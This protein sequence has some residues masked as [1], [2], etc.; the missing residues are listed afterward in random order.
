D[1]AGEDRSADYVLIR[2]AQQ[3]AESGE[4]D[5]IDWERVAQ[6]ALYHRKRAGTLADLY[7]ALGALNDL[8][9]TDRGGDLSRALDDPNGRRKIARTESSGRVRVAPD[10]VDSLSE[11]GRLSDANRREVNNLFGEGTSPKLRLI[12]T[13]LEAL[14]L[15]ANSFLRRNARRI[16]YG[17]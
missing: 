6:T 5:S 12:R 16:V 11:G 7:R 13:G 4:V 9:F 14:G 2:E 3:A 17:V 1:A 10:T 8:G 15:D